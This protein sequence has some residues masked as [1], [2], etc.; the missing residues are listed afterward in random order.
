MVIYVLVILIILLIVI[1]FDFRK[2]TI[3]EVSLVVFVYLLVRTNTKATPI[4]LNSLT[5]VFSL[6]H[7]RGRIVADFIKHLL[8]LFPIDFPV[9]NIVMRLPIL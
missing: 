5:L 4:G 3:P 7:Q 1:L 9:T 2:L 8:L 6:L